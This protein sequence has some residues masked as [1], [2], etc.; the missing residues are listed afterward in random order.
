MAGVIFFNICMNANAGSIEK[1]CQLILDTPVGIIRIYI[2]LELIGS[3]AGIQIKGITAW[4]KS[5]LVIL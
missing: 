2:E 5:K 1:L 3:T 4:F